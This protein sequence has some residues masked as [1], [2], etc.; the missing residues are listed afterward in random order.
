[1]ERQSADTTRLLANADRQWD[2]MAEA[3]R[4]EEMEQ[5]VDARREARWKALERLESADRSLYLRRA[6]GP[7]RDSALVAL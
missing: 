1:M 2:G 4:A 6:S 3:I 5:A 7:A